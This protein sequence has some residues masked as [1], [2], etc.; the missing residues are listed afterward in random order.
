MNDS[1]IYSSDDDDSIKTEQVED[2]IKKE[3]ELEVDGEVIK[4]EVDDDEV[5][6]SEVDDGEIIKAE[7]HDSDEE[8]EPGELICAEPV[9]EIEVDQPSD[10]EENIAKEPNDPYESHAFIGVDEIDPLD[11]LGMVS[12]KMP[13]ITIFWSLEFLAIFMRRNST[14]FTI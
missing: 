8:S 9:I 2:D 7:I 13:I 11:P 5:V 10:T 6:K 12:N 3:E 1:A 4:A 14:V